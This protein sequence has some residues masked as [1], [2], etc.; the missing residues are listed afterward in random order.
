MHPITDPTIIYIVFCL[1]TQRKPHTFY[2]PHHK[3]CGRFIFQ[4]S[5]TTTTRIKVHNISFPYVY[6]SSPATQLL[7]NWKFIQCVTNII[8]KKPQKFLVECPNFE[9]NWYKYWQTFHNGSLWT[10]WNFSS[11]QK[12]IVLSSFTI[13]VLAFVLC[14]RYIYRWCNK[15][16]NVH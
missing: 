14:L 7:W 1:K 13:I 3:V 8:L 11:P 2:F 9:F 15:I 5:A 6:T 10:F 12:K 4:S 16:S